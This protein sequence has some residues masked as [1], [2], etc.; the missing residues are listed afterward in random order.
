MSCEDEESDEVTSKE[1]R[2]AAAKA[3]RGAWAT[4]LVR[5]CG[6]TEAEAATIARRTYPDCHYKKVN[7]DVLRYYIANP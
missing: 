3:Q 6:N 2:R 4:M 7:D 5:D 1:L